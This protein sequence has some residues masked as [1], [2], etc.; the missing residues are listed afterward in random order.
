MVSNTE[1]VVG[2][3]VQVPGAGGRFNEAFISDVPTAPFALE[4]ST[5][6]YI[7]D[8]AG[9]RLKTSLF[10]NKLEVFVPKDSK[11]KEKYK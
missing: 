9:I 5:K 1:I 2:V 10:R 8:P 4:A 3:I 6:K 11:I 7:S